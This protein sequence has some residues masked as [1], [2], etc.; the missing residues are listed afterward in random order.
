MEEDHRIESS[1]SSLE[2]MYARSA[3]LRVLWQVSSEAKAALSTYMPLFKSA[4]CRN[5]IYYFI[6]SLRMIES[7]KDSS[8]IPP[9][10]RLDIANQ[11]PLCILLPYFPSSRLVGSGCLFVLAELTFIVY[12]GTTRVFVTTIIET[13]YPTTEEPHPSNQAHLNQHRYCI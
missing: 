2:Y 8:I 1:R 12:L 3:T 13:Q 9:I 6:S 4:S 10:S 5:N 11:L 7:L